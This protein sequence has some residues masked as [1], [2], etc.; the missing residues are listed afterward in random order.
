MMTIDSVEQKAFG[1]KNYEDGEHIGKLHEGFNSK[2]KAI[3]GLYE[4]FDSS[5]SKSVARWL[6]TEGSLNISLSDAH[7]AVKEMV[8]GKDFEW[9]GETRTTRN[10]EQISHWKRNPDY[11]DQNVK[12]HAGY[13]AEVISKEKDNLLAKAD[14]SGVRTYV[15]DDRPDMFHKNDPYVDKIRVNSNGD[16]IERIQV[17]FVGDSPEQCLSKLKSK[18]YDK[19]FNDGKVDKVEVPKDY[20]DRM[21]ALIP[22][23]KA[24]LE[25]QFERLK[26]EGK[27]DIAVKKQAEI[28]RYNKID[29]ML[30]KSTVT[31]DEARYAVE[32]PKRYAAKIMTG[33]V[34]NAGNREGLKSGAEAAAL[35]AAVSTVDNIQKVMD[36][37]VTPQ[38]AALDVV[39]DTAIAGG[40][41]YGT[42]F[43]STAVGQTMS[44][45]SHALIRAAGKAGVASA[46]ISFGV[47]SYESVIDYAQGRIDGKELANDLGENAARVT[48]GALGSAVAG[49]A[50]GSVV[51]GAGTA[52]GFAVGM[53]GGMVGTAVASE[54]YA[55]AVENAP[56]A[57][58]I[59]GDKA[60]TFAAK[61]VETAQ[62]YAPEK[63]ETVKTALNDFINVNKLPM[64]I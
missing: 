15:A 18:K 27:D 63:V 55:T 17:K 60:Q 54:A 34:A 9:N 8:H 21:K 28:E 24:S 52:V 51:P 10:L 36:G 19:Y 29:H 38:E 44:A 59:L 16:I 42:A 35:T 3:N 1:R 64:K 56:E 31:T 41:G 4:N 39:K 20:Y 43:V 12:Q 62:R 48:G 32:H 23:K 61:T 58:K 49:A 53:V 6:G 30:E 2:V 13:A 45:S 33:E 50:L 14:K 5:V 40:A 37:E 57:A 25:K 46:A 11:Y 7:D 22:E 47:E 26:M